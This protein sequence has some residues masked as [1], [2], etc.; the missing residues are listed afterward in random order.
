MLETEENKQTHVTE[1]FTTESEQEAADGETKKRPESDTVSFFNIPNAFILKSF[2]PDAVYPQQ[3]VLHS[4]H[5]MAPL[6]MLYSPQSALNTAPLLNR[7][8][9]ALQFIPF[10]HRRSKFKWGGQHLLL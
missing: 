3:A 4:H 9:L 7:T 10:S 8:D 5:K 6:T 2:F 1:S